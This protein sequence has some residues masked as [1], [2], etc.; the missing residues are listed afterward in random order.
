[1]EV[2]IYLMALFDTFLLICVAIDISS[3][4]EMAKKIRLIEKQV[5]EGHKCP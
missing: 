5:S 4:K 1:M 3:I 2:A